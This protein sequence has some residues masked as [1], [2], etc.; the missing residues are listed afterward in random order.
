MVVLKHERPRPAVEAEYADGGGV[1]KA[2]VVDALDLSDVFGATRRRADLSS[3]KPADAG[4]RPRPTRG[5]ARGSKRKRSRGSPRPCRPFS[6][7]RNTEEVN[8]GDAR[9][10]GRGA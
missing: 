7:A 8:G 6:R 10:G 9:R 1:T 4:S 5:T 3:L 2:F